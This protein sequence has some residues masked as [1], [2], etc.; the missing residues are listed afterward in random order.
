MISRL[1]S[2]ICVVFVV[3]LTSC[4]LPR[5]NLSQNYS[6]NEEKG[7]VFFSLTASGECNFNYFIDIRNIISKMSESI[8]MNDL[9]DGLD[10]EK[11]ENDCPSTVDNYHG[12]L[13]AID[14]PEGT[15]DIY[16]LT[17]VNLNSRIS[18]EEDIV[19]R[20]NVRKNEVTYLGNVH[21]HINKKGFSFGVRDST[22]RDITHFK[23]K[24]EKLGEEDIKIQII[25]LRR[26]RDFNNNPSITA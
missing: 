9:I 15:Y 21:F 19:M 5:S 25:E 16:D 22:E 11:E 26:K 18:S 12:R 1:L 4:A 6:L 20:F 3:C 7:V 17:G 23:K 8:G 24:F 2:F 14:L 10:W 13:V